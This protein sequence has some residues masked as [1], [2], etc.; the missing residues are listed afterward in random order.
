MIGL[1]SEFLKCDDLCKKYDKCISLG[2]NCF[3][4]MILRE[5][6][7]QQYSYPFDW[8][9]GI[10]EDKAGVLG[11]EGK[12]D[13]LCSNFLRWIELD[14]L[15]I[16]DHNDWVPQKP[17]MNVRNIHTGLQYVHDFAKGKTIA[18]SYPEFRDKYIRRKNRLQEIL[19]SSEKIAFV[20]YAGMKFLNND[21]ILRCFE[22]L[23]KV[24][25]TA[26]FDFL[27][28]Q[29]NPYMDEDKIALEKL[30]NNITK[31]SLYNSPFDETIQG[32]LDIVKPRIK[33]IFTKLLSVDF[34]D[35]IYYPDQ[36]SSKFLD[37]E[38][39]RNPS[40]NYSGII[41]YGPYV[42]LPAGKF[43]ISIAYELSKYYAASYDIVSNLGKD[44][45]TKGILS[46]ECTEM[47][48]CIDLADKTSKIEIRTFV[49]CQND[50]TDNSFILKSIKI[51]NITQQ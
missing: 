15:I 38:V 49:H 42:T 37:K 30:N 16:I 18:E 2:F 5:C 20:F 21:I 12:I 23:K 9:R 27:I 45:L 46:P 36:L 47:K 50:N 26:D 28:I 51:K 25:P 31:I 33:D 14:D 13:L 6:G 44:I 48:I 3:T 43:E 4:S 41:S 39:I 8:S 22:K 7:L 17:H 29:N 40:P 11:L 24:Y 35:K 10:E 19:N 34:S 32:N 1:Y